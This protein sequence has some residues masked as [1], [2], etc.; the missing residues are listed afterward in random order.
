MT[1]PKQGK[2]ESAAAGAVPGTHHFRFHRP[3]MHLDSVFG[4]GWFAL[5]AEAFARFFGTPVFLIAQTLIVALWITI[6]VSDLGF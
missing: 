3:N 4:D 6:N 1:T 5:R 2:T